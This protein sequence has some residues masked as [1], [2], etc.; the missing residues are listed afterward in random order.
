MSVLFRFPLNKDFSAIIYPKSSKARKIL[1]LLIKE[2]QKNN[3]YMSRHRLSSFASSIK[4]GKFLWH[5]SP[6]YSSRKYT[7]KIIKDMMG[8]GMLEFRVGNVGGKFKRG[9]FLEFTEF[10]RRLGS[11]ARKWEKC[12]ENS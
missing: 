10:S 12:F 4:Q 11:I 3:G 9:Y 1:R 7:Y 6:F 8:M 5:N 2:F